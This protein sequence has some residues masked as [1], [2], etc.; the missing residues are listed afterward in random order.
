M[1]QVGDHAIDIRG[2]TVHEAIARGTSAVVFRGVQQSLGRPVAIKVFRS[3]FA[4]D[5]DAEAFRTEIAALGRLSNHPNIVSVIEADVTVDGIGF[6]VSALMEGSLV[7]MCDADPAALARHL[8]IGTKIAG[9][10]S[11]AHGAGFVHCDVKP[12]NVL[13]SEYGEPALSD[14]G[15]ATYPGSSG[16]PG[17]HRITLDYAAPELLAGAGAVPESDVFSWAA[18]IHYLLTGS[19]PHRR[20]RT[21][22]VESFTERIRNDPYQPPSVAPAIDDALGDLLGS[23]LEV[24]PGDRPTAAEFADALN[25]IAEMAGFPPTQIVGTADIPD[26]GAGTGINTEVG[27]PTW[28]P[29]GG[30]GLTGPAPTEGSRR[31]TSLL[32]VAGLVLLIA[33]IVAVVASVSAAPSPL[34]VTRDDPMSVVLES[35]RDRTVS[36]AT[37]GEV[38]PV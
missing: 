37:S 26:H 33:G 36:E 32:S 23:S 1:A 11:V 7:G 2:Y 34:N 31:Q 3:S 5:H 10:L 16:G 22:S 24:R 15:S 20:D 13:L 18:T 28:P 8:R 14:F 6:I 19:P 4:N 25:D 35:P 17:G 38:A 12:G 9:A 21:E 29:S 30:S 27:P